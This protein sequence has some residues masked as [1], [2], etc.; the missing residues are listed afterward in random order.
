[1]LLA[2]AEANNFAAVAKAKAV[3]QVKFL[4]YFK[5]YFFLFSEDDGGSLRW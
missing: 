5:I 3:Y 4:F 2:T 1:M